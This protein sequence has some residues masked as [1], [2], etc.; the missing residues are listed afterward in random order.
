MPT[1]G[2]ARREWTQAVV[3]AYHP[4][5]VN[6]LLSLPHWIRLSEHVVARDLDATLQTLDV[7]PLQVL[8]IEPER[9]TLNLDSE[10]QA[11][12]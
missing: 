10:A 7:G 9:L 11:P 5:A 6:L 12:C 1:A 8:A 3:P 4:S 2:S